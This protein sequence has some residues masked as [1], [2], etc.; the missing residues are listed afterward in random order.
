MFYGGVFNKTLN[1]AANP[2][3]PRFVK[4]P[5]GCFLKIFFIFYYYREMKQ[6]QHIRERYLR[7]SRY[8]I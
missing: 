4:I 6:S 2:Q 3:G 8:S 5:R 7:Y 1:T